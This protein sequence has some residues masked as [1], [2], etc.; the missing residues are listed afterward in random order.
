MLDRPFY[1]LTPQKRSSRWAGMLP[2]VVTYTRLELVRA[3][4]WYLIALA[5]ALGGLAVG[6]LVYFF[7]R[8]AKG[9][10]VP[11]V[12]EAIA[13]RGGAIRARVVAI[14][15]LASAISSTCPE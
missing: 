9:H 15:T 2:P 8:E 7:A 4:P 1:A 13:L 14:K 6:P 12:M 5:P 10:G 3:L 11:E